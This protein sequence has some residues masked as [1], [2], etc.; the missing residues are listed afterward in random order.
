VGVHPSGLDV[1][2]LRALR[3]SGVEILSVE[4]YTHAEE[5]PPHAELQ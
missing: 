5:A 4:V 2:F 1:D 3:H